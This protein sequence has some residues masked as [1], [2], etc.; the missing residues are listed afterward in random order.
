[1]AN[2]T[3]NKPAAT[4]VYDSSLGFTTSVKAAVAMIE[5]AGLPQELVNKKLP[6]LQTGFVGAGTGRAPSWDATGFPYTPNAGD[7]CL[8]YRY[9]SKCMSFVAGSPSWSSS[10]VRTILAVFK[11]N[12]VAMGP[13][14]IT[15]TATMMTVGGSAA[16]SFGQ[17]IRLSVANTGTTTV[18]VMRNAG[19]LT[20]TQ[21]LTAG[22]WYAIALTFDD[23]GGTKN[24]I[25]RLYRYSDQTLVTSA[26]GLITADGSSNP[27][28]PSL[29]DFNL[30]SITGGDI[31]F[32]G[33]FYCAGTH[34]GAFSD[35]NFQSFYEDPVGALGCRGTYTPSGSLTAGTA[36]LG[37][38]TDTSITVTATRAL[39]TGTSGT[40]S[41]SYQWQRST[42]ATTGFANLSGQTSL[43]CT[44]TT[45]L[46]GV[47]YYYQIVATDGS[48]SVTYPSGQP[49]G[50]MLRAAPALGIVFCGDSL[51]ESYSMP[52][53]AARILSGANVVVQW[54]NRGKSGAYCASATSSPSWS[55][56]VGPAI[57]SLTVTGGTPSSGKF[58]IACTAGGST[59]NTANIN[60][61]DSAATI[62]AAIEALANFGSGQV[63]CTGGP[64]PGTAVTIT[65][66]GT[67]ALATVTFAMQTSSNTMNNSAAPTFTL[68]Q[69]GYP[70]GDLWA[71]TL[72]VINADSAN[73]NYI[74]LQIGTNDMVA[75]GLS[76]AQF[77]M[78]L[79]QTVANFRSEAP[80]C[81]VILSAPPWRTSSATAANT[82]TLRQCQD[83]IRS[84]ADGVNVLV[85]DTANWA[86][87]MNTSYDLNVDGT[88]PNNHLTFQYGGNWARAIERVA[89]PFG[90]RFSGNVRSGSNV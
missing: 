68:T 52:L 47:T 5:G 25:I 57:T 67:L 18:L 78:N 62:Q 69:Q 50:A 27:T 81:K 23:S 29:T 28:A 8:R 80:G 31:A 34:T 70:V 14:G 79:Q 19:T 71:P 49:V 24:R 84:V 33:S 22:E 82:E 85:G 3:T 15:Q 9:A 65:A 88:H 10:S 63:T 58:N 30:G 77:L 75:G 42:T 87:L 12:H 56:G 44:D 59:T 46:K 38:V 37:A 86:Y 1:M 13:S 35:A 16:D 60:Y 66:A 45:A 39:G 89:M 53:A 76:A 73:W 6:S 72:A 64:L 43:T 20:T 48:D 40:G 83:A 54:T 51:T 7:P 26:G 17:G 61:N 90:L 2:P 36:K 21:T 11:H 55:K 4:S 32:V 41:P 74:H